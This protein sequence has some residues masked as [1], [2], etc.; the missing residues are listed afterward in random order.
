MRPGR[1]LCCVVLAS[2]C[3]AGGCVQALLGDDEYV[4]DDDASGGGVG[5][6]AYK[7]GPLACDSGLAACGAACVDLESDPDHCGRCD[8]ACGSPCS[9]G[10]CEPTPVA[11]DVE[12]PQA[13]ALDDTHVYWTTAGG[14][15]QRAPK[16]GGPVQTIAEDQESPTT[17]IVDEKRAYWLN[18]GTGA[19]M[20]QFK[21]GKATPMMLSSGMGAR[22]LAQ[23]PS[24][25][26]FSRKVKKGDIRVVPKGGGGPVNLALQQPLPADL[27]IRGETLFW[28]GHA[29]DDDDLNGNS[30]PDGEEGLSGGYVRSMPRLGPEAIL[31]LAQAEGEISALTTLAGVPV[32]ADRTYARIRAYSPDQGGPITLVPDQD[33]RGLTSD[34]GAIYWS[35]AGGNVKSRSAQGAT[36]IIALDVTRAGPLVVDA[37]HVYL[38]RTGPSGGVLRVAK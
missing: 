2:L 6:V 4:H 37:T 11:P 20:R 18:S 26:Y 30:I 28:S 21:D 3:S 9:Q 10:L 35:T 38:L 32:W 27:H 1:F 24:S 15:V 31:T 13:I 34:E 5:G 17:I 19:V 33:V 25:I 22:G 14:A 23:D 7:T 16:A 36:A 12:D 29:D 8:R